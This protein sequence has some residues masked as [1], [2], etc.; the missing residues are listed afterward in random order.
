[1]PGLRIEIGVTRATVDR[2]VTDAKIGQTLRFVCAH[3]DIAGDVGHDVVHT[4]G[5]TEAKLAE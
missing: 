4:K 3:R 1:M 5:S 2:C